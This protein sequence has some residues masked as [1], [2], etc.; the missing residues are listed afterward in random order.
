MVTQ[1]QWFWLDDTVDFLLE[2]DESGD[3]SSVGGLPSD[4]ELID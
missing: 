1:K 2:S 3:D 4:E